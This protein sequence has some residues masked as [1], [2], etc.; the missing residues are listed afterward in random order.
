MFVAIIAMFMNL[1]RKRIAATQFAIYMSLANLSRS[2]GA[3]LAGAVSAG[4]TWS[5]NFLLIAGFAA[6]ALACLAFFSPERHARHLRRLEERETA[7][8]MPRA[9]AREPAS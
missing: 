3:F 6:A 1:C 9:E 2:A 8:G 5:E 4:L 7:S